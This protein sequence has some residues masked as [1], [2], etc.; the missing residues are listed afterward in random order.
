MKKWL[1]DVNHSYLDFYFIKF[2]LLHFLS[3]KKHLI[4]KSRRWYC[5]LFQSLFLKASYSGNKKG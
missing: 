2:I 5:L 4:Y 1:N 3:L